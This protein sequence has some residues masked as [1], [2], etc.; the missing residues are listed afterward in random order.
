MEASKDTWKRTW[1]GFLHHLGVSGANYAQQALTTPNTTYAKLSLR[2]SK[3]YIGATGKTLLEREA[4]R[5]RTHRRRYPIN[6]EPSI[7]WWK[8]SKSFFE[9]A[10]IAIANH[11]TKSQAYQ[12]ETAIRQVRKPELNAPQIWRHIKVKAFKMP[13][14][15]RINLRQ[16]AGNSLTRV[17]WI[18]N[19]P[20]TWT[21]DAH[22]RLWNITSALAQ[23]GGA[24][25]QIMH[26]L[27]STKTK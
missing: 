21:N 2:R 1:I 9:F 23:R 17:N 12:L 5:R 16:R 22:Q 4:A 15:K 27:M 24:S 10:P 3:A 6:M 8:Q 18:G 7:K 13:T 20:P 25:D 14:P 11:Q 26:Q 19:V